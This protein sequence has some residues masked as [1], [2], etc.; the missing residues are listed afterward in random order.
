[1]RIAQRR[2]HVEAEGVGVLDLGVAEADDVDAALLVDLLE[3]ERLS[4]RRWLLLQLE[5]ERLS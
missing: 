2:R 5:Q 1:V 3:Q 4:S